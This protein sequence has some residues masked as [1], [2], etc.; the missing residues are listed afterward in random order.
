MAKKKKETYAQEAVSK[1]SHLPKIL[2]ISGIVLLVLVG[3][4]WGY[5]HFTTNIGH[6]NILENITI[7]GVNVGGMSQQEAIEALTEATRDTYA[8]VPMQIHIHKDTHTIDIDV[9]TL[10]LD[11]E[12]AVAEAYQFGRQGFYFQRMEEQKQVAD[13]GYQVDIFPHLGLDTEDIRNQIDAIALAYN[14]PV[15]Q[16]K[17]E[18]TGTKADLSAQS[19]DKGTLALNVTM[20]IPGYTLDADALYELVID[21]YNHNCLEVY[22][23]CDVVEPDAPDLKSICDQT[24]VD[25]VDAVMDQKTFEV[26]PHS[27]GYQFDY[28]KA[29]QDIHEAKYGQALTFPYEKVAP[30]VLEETLSALLFR[31]VL[32]SYTS[33]TSSSYSRDVNKR[34]SCEAIDGVVLLP[35]EIFSYNPTLGERTAEAGYQPAPSYSGMETVMEYGG[36]I[37]Q[38]SSTLYYCAMLADLEIVERYN[39]GFICSYMPFGM[40]ATVSWGGPEFRFKNNTEYPIR[41]EATASGGDVTVKLIGTDTKD[42]YVKMTYEVLSV[43]N[44]KTV[45]MEMEE[46]NPKGYKDGEEIMSP[47]TGYKVRTYR[48]KYSKA[49]NE[50]ISSEVEATSNYSVRDRVICKIKKPNATDPTTPS[51]EPTTEPTTAPTETTE[52]TTQPTETSEETIAPDETQEST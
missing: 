40:D 30:Q 1:V 17:T 10:N 41:I 48:C 9:N 51:T 26:I 4:A 11:V 50:L 46:N 14:H 39:H 18:L 19:T 35:G 7:A 5:L 27:Y 6:D 44:Y 13:S 28:D 3:A 20:G 47:Y 49:T 31:D 24:F 22:A 32:S 12:S 21:A 25:P 52:P 16:P 43:T 38:A 23:E 42:Y 45:E 2:L 29:M 37:C 36:G 33:Y 8:K 34:L 15:I